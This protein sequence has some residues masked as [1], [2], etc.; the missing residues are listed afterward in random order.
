[1]ERRTQAG[2]L[3]NHHSSAKSRHTGFTLTELLAVIALIAILAV[4][5]LAATVHPT[6]RS[7]RIQCAA[8]LHQ[9]FVGS[10]VYGDDF[11]KLPLWQSGMGDKENDMRMDQ[12]SLWVY[13]GA[14]KERPP[15][16]F[17]LPRG[18]SF[19]NMGY[20][21]GMKIAGEG[22]IFFC[23]ALKTGPYSE[24]Q[25]S[26]LM[27]CDKDGAIRSSYNYNPRMIN[28]DPGLGPV[29]TH[30]RIV[31][32]TEMRSK[33]RVFAMDVIA[34]SFAHSQDQ[35]WNVMFTDGSARF[36]K[37]TDPTVAKLVKEARAGTLTSREQLFDD[38]E[39]R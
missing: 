36:C 8:Y 10:V 15:L 22:R 34:E 32:S 5:L 9:L 35:G 29:D 17:N 19:Q 28:A 6:R 4:L 31:N 11:G 12:N 1:M 25:Y 2:F 21:Y 33:R 39:R 38:F 3:Q 30:R 13:S 26:P 7:T 14:P 18:A 27:T 16:S 23:P 20:L 24:G 37:G